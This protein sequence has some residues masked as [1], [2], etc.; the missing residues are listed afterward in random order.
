MASCDWQKRKGAGEAKAVFRHCD[1]KERE[2]ANHSNKDIDKSRTYMNMSFGFYDNPNGY[3]AICNAYDG[4]I[5]YLDNKSGANKRKDRVTLLALNIPAPAGMTDEQAQEWFIEAYKVLYDCFG[6]NLLGGTAHFDEVH[7][8]TNASTGEKQESR[9]HLQAQVFP[10]VAERLNAKALASRKNMIMVNNRLEEMTKARFPEFTFMDGTKR[11]SRKTVEELKQASDVLSV[12]VEAQ[13]EAAKIVEEARQR[14]D[15]L[16][17]EAVEQ[18]EKAE[19]YAVELR[20]NVSDE[21]EA[22]RRKAKK[23]VEASKKAILEDAKAE[24]DR[25]KLEA[26]KTLK[27]ANTSLQRARQTDEELQKAKLLYKNAYDDAKCIAEGFA[28][29]AFYKRFFDT[30]RQGLESVQYQSGRNGWDNFGV[31]AEKALEEAKKVTKYYN[32]SPIDAYQERVAERVQ[33]AKTAECKA[34]E[35]PDL[36]YDVNTGYK[37]DGYS[38]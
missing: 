14:A 33:K 15:R 30:F 5:A 36:P 32:T 8:Y 34:R 4:R 24:A 28:E 11:K 6:D 21:V 2:K 22:Y 23:D 1:T 17:A 3:E 31:Y 19:Q 12:T 38:R 7:A 16:D 26:Q 35:I 9:P 10:E 29:E 37:N 13:R 18:A 27:T 20:Q 25:I